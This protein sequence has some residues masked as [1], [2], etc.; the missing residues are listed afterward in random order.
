VRSGSYNVGVDKHVIG[1]DG[2]TNNALHG[3]CRV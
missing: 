2:G 3:A 1:N